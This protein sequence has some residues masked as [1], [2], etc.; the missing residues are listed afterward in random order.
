MTTTHSNDPILSPKTRQ[1]RITVEQYAIR[2]HADAFTLAILDFQVFLVNTHPLGSP[3]LPLV[4]C[5]V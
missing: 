1:S 3:V 2:I 4:N 5:T